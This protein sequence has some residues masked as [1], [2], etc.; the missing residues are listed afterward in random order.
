MLAR[1]E[2]S[3]NRG[4]VRERAGGARRSHVLGLVDMQHNQSCQTFK[5][6]SSTHTTRGRCGAHQQDY[7]LSDIALL[8]QTCQAGGGVTVSARTVGGRDA[9]YKAA[10][11]AAVRRCVCVWSLRLAPGC[12]CRLHT[13]DSLLLLLFFVVHWLAQLHGAGQR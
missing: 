2:Q 3:K 5:L 9:I 11:D 13:E 6:P 1:L 7:K 12:F 10:V 4:E 8:R